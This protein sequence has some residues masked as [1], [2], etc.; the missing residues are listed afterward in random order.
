MRM[1][2]KYAVCTELLIPQAVKRDFPWNGLQ[3]KQP[4]IWPALVVSGRR[5]GEVEME[6][7]QKA[8]EEENMRKGGCGGAGGGEE[9]WKRR[10]G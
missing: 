5:K 3:R 1:L 4:V 8:D 7:L 2:R 9:R 10:R 6:T